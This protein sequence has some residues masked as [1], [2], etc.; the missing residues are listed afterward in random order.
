MKI[1]FYLPVKIT[2]KPKFVAFLAFVC[3][4]ASFIAQISCF[5][6]VS[7]RDTI[8]APGAKLWLANWR[9]FRV[10]GANQNARKLLST[11]LIW[12]ILMLDGV[13]HCWKM[14]DGF[15][16]VFRDDFGCYWMVLNAAGYCL[17]ALDGGQQCWRYWMF[18]DFARR[19]WKQLEAALACKIFV[20]MISPILTYIVTV[21]FGVCM[22]NQT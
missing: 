9:I 2:D 11:V 18:V 14:L 5:R 21:K 3:T 6:N 15:G 7:K 17:M 12:W 20:T 13:K 1:I 8:L 22:P 16:S 19:V 10:T 4:N